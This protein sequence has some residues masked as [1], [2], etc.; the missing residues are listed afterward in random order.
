[1]VTGIYV[2]NVYRNCGSFDSSGKTIEYDKDVIYC[3]VLDKER[4]LIPKTYTGKHTDIVLIGC[5]D[6]QDLIGH[7]VML[8]TEARM[9][10]GKP[11]DVV[12]SIMV[13]PPEMGGE[14]IEIVIHAA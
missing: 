13:I 12:Q 9:S 14:M 8:L 4:G 2:T 6:V 5:N 7:E 1:M 3:Q 11:T 10:N